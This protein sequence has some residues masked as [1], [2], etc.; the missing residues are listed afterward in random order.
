MSNR[1][2][3]PIPAINGCKAGSFQPNKLLTTCQKD[4][5]ALDENVSGLKKKINWKISK[6]EIGHIFT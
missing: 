3:C 2:E 4:K 6:E 5:M 1:F